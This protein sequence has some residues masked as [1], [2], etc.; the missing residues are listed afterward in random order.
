VETVWAATERELAPEDWRAPSRC[1]GWDVACLFA[2][3]SRFPLA[4]SGPPLAAPEHT[5]HEETFDARANLDA[6]EILARFN[7]PGG[8]AHSLAGPVSDQ[9]RTEASHLSH[10]ELVERFE[11]AGPQALARSATPDQTSSDPCRVL[12]GV[13]L[14]AP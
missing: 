10:D 12:P 3:V 4:L 13:F 6:A 2:H 1:E 14:P 9:A 5:G 7:R 11:I 8:A